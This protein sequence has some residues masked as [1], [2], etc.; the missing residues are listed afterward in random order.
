MSGAPVFAAAARGHPLITWLW[1]LGRVY[2]SGSHETVAIGE[3]VL[4]RLPALGYCGVRRQAQPP[5][6]SMKE[7]SLLVLEPWPEG[8]VSGLAY[9]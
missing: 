6:L 1:W 5:S 4:G 3:M 7:A 8:L 2:I 9:S